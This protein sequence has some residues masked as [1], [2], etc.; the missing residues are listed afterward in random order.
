ML[1]FQI[2]QPIGSSTKEAKD[3]QRQVDE[4]LQKGFVRES[5]SPCSISVILVPKKDETWRMC[6]DCLA[7]NKITVKYRYPI[8]ILDDKLD[9]LHGSVCSF[10]LLSERAEVEAR[11][12][13]V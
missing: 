2:G 11:G 7:I 9:E 12:I 1:H 13:R 8:P 4:F 10:H 5:L 6:T 3:I